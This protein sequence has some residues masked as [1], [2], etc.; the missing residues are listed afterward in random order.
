MM[1]LDRYPIATAEMMTRQ[2]RL[3]VFVL[4]GTGFLL[5]VD[6]SILNVA[7]PQVGAA[8]GL[9]G[10]SSLPWILIAYALPAA[11]FT[12]LFG[13]IADL[14]GR[15]RLFLI[16]IGSLATTACSQSAPTTRQRP[17]DDNHRQAA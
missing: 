12:L 2:Q 11:G 5:S 6:Y 4:L 16:G 3:S 13:R 10:S 1:T 15:Y 7:L 8:V 17:A 14:F 9:D